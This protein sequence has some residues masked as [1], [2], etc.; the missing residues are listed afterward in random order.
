LR[1][2]RAFCVVAAVMLL[3]GCGGT[4]KKGDGGKAGE[5]R[6]VVTNFLS[7]VRLHQGSRAC[8]YLDASQKF[9]LEGLKPCANSV[10]S[11]AVPVG[12]TI[13]AASQN[14]ATA[15]V[16]LRAPNGDYYAYDLRREGG[17]LKIDG[18]VGP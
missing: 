2:V 6:T 10:Q 13:Y 16:N 14:A 18:R 9:K 15:R 11:I 5:A 8:S 1:F 4:S 12:S 7:A 3:A 17:P